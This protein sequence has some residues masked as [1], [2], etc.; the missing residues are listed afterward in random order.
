MHTANTALLM[1]YARLWDCHDVDG[2]VA[3]FTDDLIYT[4][5]ALGWV[6]RG[7]HEFREFAAKVFAMHPDFHI[8]YLDA[9][10]TDTRGAAEWIIET[11][12]EGEFEGVQVTGGQLSFRGT[13]LFELRDGHICRNTD[14]WNY[15]DW[16]R[17]L[18]VATLRSA[19]QSSE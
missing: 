13:T 7:K 19:D 15:A 4:D 1:T 3:L 10:A 17:Q 16:M 12:F 8:R 9:F 18:G 14:S 11:R 6:H 2:L 5:T